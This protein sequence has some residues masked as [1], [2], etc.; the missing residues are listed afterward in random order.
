MRFMSSNYA[1]SLNL[2]SREFA[3]KCADTWHHDLTNKGAVV[4]LNF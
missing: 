1:S 4:E 3:Q 2:H